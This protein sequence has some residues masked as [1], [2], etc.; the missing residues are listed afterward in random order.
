M[1]DHEKL[2]RPA[3]C[4][5]PELF[6]ALKWGRTCAEQTFLLSLADAIEG[7]K[8]DGNLRDLLDGE[9][10]DDADWWEKADD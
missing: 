5:L 3:A 4:T 7:G 1:E 9:A 10:R 6:R 2:Q 8:L